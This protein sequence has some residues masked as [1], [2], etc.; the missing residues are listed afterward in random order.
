[1]LE[2]PPHLG[3]NAMLTGWQRSSCPYSELCPALVQ[4]EGVLMVVGPHS[5]SFRDGEE[6]GVT[7]AHSLP[8]AEALV[9]WPEEQGWECTGVQ[10]ILGSLPGW[11]PP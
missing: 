4:E 5:S 11:L 7:S 10:S 6:A 3:L 2:I 9:A 1:M 8:R